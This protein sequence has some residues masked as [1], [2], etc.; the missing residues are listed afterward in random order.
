MGWDNYHLYSFEIGGNSYT[1][2]R[3]ADD[4]DM[5]NA[6]RTKLS[7]AVPRENIKF[8][9][10]Y[11]FGDDWD[12]Q[13]LVEKILPPEDG[14][15]YPA[16]VKGKRAGPPEDVGGS[17]GYVEF[18]EAIQDPKHERHEE[19]LEWVGGEFDPEAF[20]IDALNA[21]LRQLK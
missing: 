5:E 8:H 14:Q 13:I 16:C 4:L 21:D 1:D 12:H 10:V 11:D 6:A 20:D 7:D 17:W 9:Y 2:P 19:L 15:K 3:A 18:I